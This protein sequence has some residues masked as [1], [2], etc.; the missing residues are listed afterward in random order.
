M[1]AR[2]SGKVALV[3]GGASGIGAA[4]TALLTAEGARVLV[5]DL[6]PPASTDIAYERCDVGRA[7]QVTAAVA[8]AVRRFGRLDLLLNNAGIAGSGTVSDIEPQ[9]WARIFAVNLDSVYFACRAALPHL[10]AAGGGAVVNTASISG[11]AGDMGMA[12]YNASKGAVIN[13]TRALAIDHARDGIRVNAVCPG[14]I[15]TPLTEPVRTRP[16]LYQEW[17]QAVPMGR[18]GRPEEIAEVIAF[19]ASDAASYVTGSIVVA[20]GG[21]MAHTGQPQLR[22]P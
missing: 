21:R 5:A 17:T 2:F 11:L 9:Q 7:E 18:A 6:N 10:R 13:L 3:T 22:R 16:E 1:L 15:D 20:D 12:A 14:I 4:T 19:L 8:A